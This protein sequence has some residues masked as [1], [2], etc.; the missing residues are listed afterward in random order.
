MP[1]KKVKSISTE[2]R[3]AEVVKFLGQG[4]KRSWIIEEKAKEWSVTRHAIEKYIT[5]A[6]IIIK[7]N[8]A[9]ID[10]EYLMNMYSDLIEEAHGQGNTFL[11]KQIVDSMTKFKKDTNINVNH[12]G[13]ITNRII[14]EI[15]GDDDDKGEQD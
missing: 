7:Q 9:E 13:D 6:R 14:I 4:K 12:T 1:R 5:E 2:Q 11:K 8:M 15:I 10:D 3:V